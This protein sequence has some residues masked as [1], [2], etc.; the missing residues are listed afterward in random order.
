MKGVKLS[1]WGLLSGILVMGL[2]L[3]GTRV[4][5]EAKSLKEIAK[6]FEGTTV[7]V[8]WYTF[9]SM[10]WI[11]DLFPEFEKEY[12]IRVN[13]DVVPQAQCHEKALLEMA[14]RTGRYD[15]YTTDCMFLVEYAE[16]GYLEPIKKYVTDPNFTDPEVLAM[17]DYLPRA[18]SGNGVWRDIMYSLPIDCG[19]HLVACRKDLF[20]KYGLTYPTTGPEFEEVAV[21]LTRP[22]EKLY[23]YATA[24][25]RDW[26]LGI[27]WLDW[28]YNFG[29]KIYGPKWKV[30]IDSPESLKALNFYLNLKRFSPPG[31]G[32]FAWDE[33][34]T[35]FTQGRLGMSHAYSAF[36]VTYEDPETSKVAGKIKY[37]PTMTEPGVTEVVSRALF[38]GVGLSISVDSKNKEAAYV[39]IQWAAGKPVAK[40]AALLNGGICRYSTHLDP[41]VQKK[42][43]WTYVN[44]KYML[45]AANPDHR[46]RIPEFSEMIHSISKSGNDA[47]YERITPEKALADMQKEITEIMRK[48]G[49][50]TRGTK[51]YKTPQ[52]WLDLAYYDRAPLLWK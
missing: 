14:K 29:A 5:T 50:Y 38:G 10:L 23:G 12:G 39:F 20:E 35:Y 49:Y 7:N 41:E 3:A 51:A 8:L 6:R 13:I 21:K 24:G 2:V 18:F 44:Y 33:I 34:I 9:P 17:W 30:E 4:P 19:H 28:F 1:R 47:F 11:H 43:P 36:N 37:I 32:T 52:Y 40:R 16:P 26:E 31:S 45:H 25:R 22:E 27:A 42:W 48:A 46:P 15:V